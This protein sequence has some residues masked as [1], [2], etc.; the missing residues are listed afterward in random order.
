MINLYQSGVHNAINAEKKTMSSRKKGLTIQE[1]TVHGSTEPLPFE[2]ALAELESVVAQLEHDDLRLAD[3][4]SY[5]E[6]G[7][8]LMRICDTHLNHARGKITELLKGEDG[9]FAEKVLGI[10]LEAFL[11]EE[12]THD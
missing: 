7:I 4:L 11:N 6:Q 5:F 1:K 3:A 8:G 12:K 9:A 10:S 2:S